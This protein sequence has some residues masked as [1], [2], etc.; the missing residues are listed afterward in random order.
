MTKDTFTETSFKKGMQVKSKNGDIYDVI[1]V[2]FSE[3]SVEVPSPHPNITDTA[4]IEIE[5]IDC[6]LF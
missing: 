5:H 6:F 2:D 3:N 1:G 4:W